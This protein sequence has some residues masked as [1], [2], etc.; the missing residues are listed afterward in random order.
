[1]VRARFPLGRRRDQG[2]AHRPAVHVQEPAKTPSFQ[3]DPARGGINQF[4]ARAI[5]QARGTIVFVKLSMVNYDE[6][7]GELG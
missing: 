4:P 5:I 2:I 3:L 6:H 7:G 1:M